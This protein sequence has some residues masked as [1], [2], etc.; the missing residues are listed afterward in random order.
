MK[1]GI[2]IMLVESKLEQLIR[3][4]KRYRQ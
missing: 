2:V 4:V 1:H 3:V